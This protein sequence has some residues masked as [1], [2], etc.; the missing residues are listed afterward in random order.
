MIYKNQEVVSVKISYKV[1]N[2]KAS[3]SCHPDFT[4][5]MIAGLKR[6]GATDVKLMHYFNN[7]GVMIK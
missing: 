7:L 1:K 6:D 5:K 2:N 3:L 4:D